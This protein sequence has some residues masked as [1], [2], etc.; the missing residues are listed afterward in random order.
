MLFI[1]HKQKGNEQ[2]AGL[3]VFRA[4]ECSYHGYISWPGQTESADDNY[5][6]ACM[7]NKLFAHAGQLPL[8]IVM[9]QHVIAT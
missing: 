9:F 6:L 7:A 2:E 8:Q 1:S 4:S 5:T 3:L